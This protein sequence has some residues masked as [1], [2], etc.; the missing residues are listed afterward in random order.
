MA[1]VKIFLQP[2]ES[3]RDAEDALMKAFNLH[4][5]GDI[6]YSHVFQ[7]PAMAAL[8]EKMESIYKNISQD[9]VREISEALDEDYSDRH[10]Y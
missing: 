6:H 10:G 7:D 3:I 9:M 5:S 2:G 4:A 8:A 1:N